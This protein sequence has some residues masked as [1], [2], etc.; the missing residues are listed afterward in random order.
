MLKQETGCTRLS[1][2]FFT[3]AEKT[4]NSGMLIIIKHL[5]YATFNLSLALPKLPTLAVL[6]EGLNNY[7]C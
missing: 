4:V 6:N 5:N 7:G 3:E 2:S 1:F